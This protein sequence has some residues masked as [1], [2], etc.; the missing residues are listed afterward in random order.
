MFDLKF[1]P[2]DSDLVISTTPAGYFF[3]VDF[4]CAWSD[5]DSAE[6]FDKEAIFGVMK[7]LDFKPDGDFASFMEALMPLALCRGKVA[8]L[9]AECPTYATLGEKLV[10]TENVQKLVTM[11]QRKCSLDMTWYR[12]S[13]VK[14][15]RWDHAG[16]RSV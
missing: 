10:S 5:L 13:Q 14:P 16:L 8:A 4:Q 11:T 1:S 3:L 2:N 9:A 7:K 6:L 12:P 15:P